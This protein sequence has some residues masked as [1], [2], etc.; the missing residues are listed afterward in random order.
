MQIISTIIL[1]HADT[2]LFIP[3]ITQRSLFSPRKI[4]RV[5]MVYYTKFYLIK[6]GEV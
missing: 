5:E 3:Q 4:F 2:I 6:S 1:Y